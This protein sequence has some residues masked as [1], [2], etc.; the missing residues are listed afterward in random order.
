VPRFPI[1]LSFRLISISQN[2]F[3]VTT[4]CRRGK[5]RGRKIG[6]NKRNAKARENK[7]GKKQEENKRTKQQGNGRWK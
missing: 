7:N 4:E 6:R 2:I 3:F 1:S 5:N